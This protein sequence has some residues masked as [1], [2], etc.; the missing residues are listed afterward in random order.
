MRRFALNASLMVA[1]VFVGACGGM[2]GDMGSDMSPEGIISNALS[3]GPTSIT[4][5]AAVLDW[6][7]NELRAGSNGWTCLPDR[8]DTDG[9]DPWCV[10]QP[11]LDFLGAYVN[12]TMP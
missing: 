1:L 5:G 11:W 2:D 9:N 6:D 7:M 3:A 10:N 12:Q 4:D 8:T